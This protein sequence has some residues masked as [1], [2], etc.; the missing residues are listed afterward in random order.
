MMYLQNLD[1]LFT[2]EHNSNK[3]IP[4][5][6]T[7]QQQFLRRESQAKENEIISDLNSEEKSLLSLLIQ[8]LVCFLYLNTMLHVVIKMKMSLKKCCLL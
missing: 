7:P 8:N 1:D 6:D 5:C 2:A 4:K 3:V